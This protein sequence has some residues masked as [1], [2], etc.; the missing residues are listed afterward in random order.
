MPDDILA[1][2]N[3]AQREGVTAAKRPVPEGTGWKGLTMG[4]LHSLCART[5]AT[6]P[7][8]RG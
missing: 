1:G 2:L 5:C 7:A 3:P 6:R 4:T 8:R